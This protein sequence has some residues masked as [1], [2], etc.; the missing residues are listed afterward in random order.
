M[1]SVFETLRKAPQTE[2]DL[3][4]LTPDER[5]IVDK[6]QINGTVG[7]T[8][9]D[10]SG[11]FTGV[12]YIVGDEKQAAE[13]FVEQNKAKLEAIDFSQRNPIST[14]VDRDVYDWIL[15]A[16]GEREL[17]VYDT[18]VIERRPDDTLWCIGRQTF[19]GTPM[20]RYTESGTGSAKLD[21]VSLKALY[22]S[23]GQQ[24]SESTLAAEPAV[25]GDVRVIL[26]AFRQSTAFECRPISVDDELAI[27]KLDSDADHGEL[28]SDAAG[29]DPDVDHD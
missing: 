27:M 13:Q 14:S 26:D 28:G 20:R 7:V 5:M 3:G 12:F 1:T 29:S 9:S 8:R 4:Q 6:I 21:S 16:L 25:Q 15:H 2:I 10:T 19:E 17:E 11:N 22:E 23:L 24:I 18:V